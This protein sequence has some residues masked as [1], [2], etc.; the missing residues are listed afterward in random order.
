[1]KKLS[2]TLRIALA[3]FLAVFSSSIVPAAAAYAT[4]GTTT[5]SNNGTLKVHEEGQP[6]GT[7]SNNPHVCV[8]NFEAF[9]LDANQ[10][11]TIVI[12]NQSP[13][14]PAGQVALTLPLATDASGYGASPADSD[15]LR[16]INAANGPTLPSGHYKATLDNKF[17]TDPNGKAKSKVIW[18][19][20]A[21]TPAPIPVTPGIAMVDEC[22]TVN[23]RV[24]GTAIDEIEYT[25]TQ[26]GLTYTV[27]ATP[28]D[29]YVLDLS[30]AQGWTL[31]SDGTATYTT[32]L[33]D[34]ACTT[35]ATP[36]I[37]ALNDFCGTDNDTITL[38]QNAGGVTYTQS[39]KNGNT[40]VVTATP[41]ASHTLAV[42]TTG[43]I[44]QTDG[45]ATYSVTFTDNAPCP[46]TPVT[47]GTPT[48]TDQCGTKN[49]TYTLPTTDHVTYTAVKHGTTVTV[50][51]TPDTGYILQLMSHSGWTLHHNGTASYTISFSSKPCPPQNP[52]VVVSTPDT[53][54]EYGAKDGTVSVQITNPN[55]NTKTYRIAVGYA[56]QDVTVP[57]NSTTTVSFDHLG[58]G[59]YTVR[60]FETTYSQYLWLTPFPWKLVD[61]ETITL[62]SCPPT[63]VTPVT[64]QFYDYCNTSDYVYIPYAKGVV[65]EINGHK[66]HAGYHKI[67]NSG[68]VTV[69]AEVYGHK[70]VLADGAT[71]SWSFTFTDAGCLSISKK[72]ISFTDTNRDGRTDYGDTANWEITVT[73]T[74]NSADTNAARTYQNFTVQVADPG[75]TLENGGYIASLAPGESTTLTATSVLTS[76]AGPVQ[77]ICTVSNTATFSAQ[78]AQREEELSTF[79]T[80]QNHEWSPL[81]GSASADATFA[82]PTPGKGGI[83]PTPPPTTPKPATPAALPAELPHT[84]PSGGYL[85]LIAGIFTAIMTYGVLYFAQPKKWYQGE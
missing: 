73:N 38:P 27:T 28:E 85:F 56:N 52:I 3:L 14:Q 72:F 22:G 43:Y 2:Q 74:A 65:Y 51:A 76:T 15:S 47:P 57:A 41:D 24:T 60:V 39:V 35:P 59:T 21:A 63:P 48:A 54:V 13:T 10:T 61:T 49:D 55:D 17:G 67:T 83:E 19:S 18:V 42:G 58:A 40:I 64:P 82:C 32:T 6:I 7:P 69:T 81:T 37:P 71:S 46:P 29:G 78:F 12:T 9:G 70:Y 62:K 77:T 66:V 79:F 11:G 33:T 84:G 68:A 31:S 36:A 26:S 30:S 5:K 45:S 53:C 80:T 20:C 4:N 25:Y 50:T 8:F 16:Y 1:M 34:T 44:L 23:D 75:A